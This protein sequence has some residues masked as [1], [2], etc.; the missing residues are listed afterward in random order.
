MAPRDSRANGIMKY[1]LDYTASQDYETGYIQR[2]IS[3]P[4]TLYPGRALF[5]RKDPRPESEFTKSK[6]KIRNYYAAGTVR[7][8]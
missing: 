3:E 2:H 8:H 4:V 1:M 6:R 5:C 7:R